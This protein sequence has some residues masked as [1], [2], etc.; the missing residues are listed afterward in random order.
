MSESNVNSTSSQQHTDSLEME[1]SN[2]QQHGSVANMENNEASDEKSSKAGLVRS[3]ARSSISSR[4]SMA[5][6]QALAEAR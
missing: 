4:A 2:Q 1:E 5:G 6:A 3:S